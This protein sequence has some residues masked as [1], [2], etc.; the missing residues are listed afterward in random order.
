MLN[1]SNMERLVD[2]HIP[3]AS[4]ALAVRDF[5]QA[6]GRARREQLVARLTGNSA[7]LLCYNDVLRALKVRAGERLGLK[8]IALDAIVGSVGRCSDFTRSFQPL[9]DNAQQRWANVCQAEVADLPP[10]RVYQLD[11]VYF[12]VDGHHRASVAR[13]R[14]AVDIAAHVITLRARVSLVPGV[15][16]DELISKGEYAAF[17]AGTRLDQVCPDADLI[18]SI[19]EQY[20]ALREQIN[21]HCHFM[22]LEQGREISYRG[23]ARHWYNEVYLP[24]V[25]VLREWEVTREFPERTEADLYLWLCEHRAT[26]AEGLGWQVSA[27]AALA[28]LVRQCGVRSQRRLTRAA[29][30]VL[31][32]LAPNGAG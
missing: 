24:V 19:P 3:S 6:Q 4:H 32:M 31:G 20:G 10:I 22:G 21:R 17:L 8:E 9:K 18:V 13:H 12:V 1:Q 14:G 2:H 28:D 25:Q 16:P 23:A 30:K 26:L 5:R 11:Q 29:R 7:N 15:Q 27:E